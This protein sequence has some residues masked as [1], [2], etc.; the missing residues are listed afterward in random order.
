MKIKKLKVQNLYEPLGIQSGHPLFSYLL[1]TKEKGQYQSAYRILVASS[2]KLLAQDIGDMWDS[3]KNNKRENFGIIYKGCQLRSRQKVYWK[4]MVWDKDGRDIGWSDISEWEMGLLDESDWQ[5]KWI[6]QGDDYQGN[7]S[8]APMFTCD[9]Q[10]INLENMRY[11]RLYISGLGL[12]TASMNG[13]E[14]S[15]TLFDPGE[16]DAGKTVYYVTYD[17]TQFVSNGRNTLGVIVGNGQYTNF[18]VNPVMTLP[19]GTEAP[20]HRYQKND[21]KIL[22]PG[23]YG[24]KK[25][26]A[27]A[28]I[29]YQDNHTE[30]VA[31]TDE[32]WKWTES[33]IVFQNWYGGEDYDATLEQKGWNT[34]GGSRD[35][36]KQALTMYPPTG[37]LTAREFLPIKIVERIA[38]KSI[39][40][41]ENGNWIV[42][43][44]RNGAGFPEL[45]LKEAMPERRG[46]WI[47]MYPAELLKTDGEGVNQASCTQSWNEKYHCSITNSY[48]IKGSK[49]ESWHPGFTYQ[50]FQYIEVEGFPGE[51]KKENITFCIIRTIN[52]KNGCF[53]SSNSTINSINNMIEH[54]MESNMFSAFT[55]CPQIE[56]LGWIE[57]S[58]LM[59]RSLA[60]SYDISSWMKKIVHDIID[61]QVDEEQASI[62]GNEPSGYVPAIIPEYQRILGLHLDPNW[63]GA[64][65]FT[66]WE[67]YLCYGDI[68][69]L[70]KAYPV[71]KKYM[72]YLSNYQTNGILENYA[73]M[74]EWGELS[75]STPTI[76]VAT[77]AYYRLLVTIQK[78]A[79]L[80]HEWN[81]SLHYKHLADKT[82][83]AFHEHPLCYNPSTRIYGNGSQASYGCALFSGLVPKSDIKDMVK[84][85]TEAIETRD[86]HLTSGEVGL[87]QVFISLG[88][89][90][91]NDIVYRMVMNET[92]PSYRFMADSG[93]TALPEYWNFNELW[94]GMER[95]RNHAMM[96]HAKEW[97]VFYMLGIRPLKPAFQE[98]LIQPYIA[99]DIQWLKGY[100]T[101]PYG[102]IVVDY[103]KENRHIR[104]KVTIPPGVQA[105]I[106][107]PCM[108]QVDY[109]LSV[110][111]EDSDMIICKTVSG[112]YEW[113]IES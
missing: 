67:Y 29:F 16:S 4:V 54:S 68:T 28:E 81:D 25:I 96:G 86:Y 26:I 35:H 62:D 6:G 55:D 85:L 13:S 7:K 69:V 47:R 20:E 105:I 48:R 112:T 53:R 17:I 1:D 72:E 91:R 82:N 36:W 46:A 52:E 12:F 66:P 58:H 65:I 76:L 22:K 57:T 77:C 45:R 44:G 19:D 51:L 27:Q 79:E 43:M 11:A 111:K 101:C 104:V 71:M 89:N 88:E 84:K 83:K 59:F 32:S 73:H 60:C 94:E 37:R 109:S 14:L 49:N 93:L 64:C 18:I 40:K 113:L 63:N 103:R 42:D 110:R 21:G 30:I 95:S 50:G 97:L 23:I 80:L 56:K 38:P 5:G 70:Q 8:S 2:K 78:I 41:L 102:E 98:V 100:I 24:D 34:P 108:E 39:R 31:A 10:A 33:P 106:M 75:E 3:G 107:K 74:G 99:N 61:A 87:K 15:D 90:N 92:S 9:F